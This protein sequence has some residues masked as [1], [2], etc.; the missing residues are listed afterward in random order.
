MSIPLPI[1]VR[2]A[3]VHTETFNSRCGLSDTFLKLKYAIPMTQEIIPMDDNTIGK[4]SSFDIR[5]S[6]TGIDG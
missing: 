3:D 4:V 1:I 2:N 5:A 6:G